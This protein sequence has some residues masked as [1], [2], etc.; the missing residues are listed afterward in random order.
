MKKIS[1]KRVITNASAAADVITSRAKKKNRLYSTSFVLLGLAVISYIVYA[2]SLT[3]YDGFM[4]S[5]NVSIRPSENMVVVEY[6]VKPGDYV[7][8]GDTL[9]SYVNVDWINKSADPYHENQIATRLIEATMRRDRLRSEYVKQVQTLDSLKKV[10]KRAK[11]DVY[12]GVATKEYMEQLEWD[13]FVAKKETE[14]TVRLIDIEHRA[15]TEASQLAGRAAKATNPIGSYSH[16]DRIKECDDFGL[17]FGY[18]VAYVDMIIVDLHARHG[19]LVMTGESIITYMPY[20]DEEMLDMHAKM[21]LDPSQFSEVQD[22]MIFDV[23]AGH[24]YLGKVRTTYQSTFINDHTIHTQDKYERAFKQ[25]DIVVR[26]EFLDKS[27]VYR[28]YQV[29][30]YPL[31]LIRYK[32]EWL[33]KIMQ[34]INLRQQASRGHELTAGTQTPNT[35]AK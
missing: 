19:V 5:R 4:V 31:R 11:E 6:M 3:T 17:S 34:K 30:K 22:S 18:R 24:D 28:K 20:N 10:V 23:Y 12:L 35:E 29:D 26:A 2:L 25:Q 14:N 33:N 15:I 9:Y 1:Y 7:K 21:L 32:W 8:E 27:C 13:M 16:S